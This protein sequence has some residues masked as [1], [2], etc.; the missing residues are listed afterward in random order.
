M[1][2]NLPNQITLGRFAL[3]ILCLLFLAMFKFDPQDP[4]PWMLD[5]AFILFVAAAGTDWLDGFLARR[6][7]QVTSFGRIL[8]PFVDKILV[9]GAFVLLLGRGF[10][11]EDGQSITGLEAWMVLIIIARELLVSGL[12][13][14]SESQGRPYGANIWGKLKMILQSVAVGWIIASAGRLRDVGWV[15]AGRP[16]VIWATVIFTTASVVA[17]LFASREAL[18]DRS[19][20]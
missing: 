7:D 12:R 15:M 19:R 8:D 9:V 18:A 1:R 13:G 11:G 5:V 3:A 10:R 14:F 20:D 17:Y 6:Q 2:T 16:V 4:T